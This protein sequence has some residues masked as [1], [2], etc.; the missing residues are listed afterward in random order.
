M[1]FLTKEISAGPPPKECLREIIEDVYE[2]SKNMLNG[3]GAAF[4]GI[5]LLQLALCGGMPPDDGEA[6]TSE[7]EVTRYN[8]NGSVESVS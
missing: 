5:G 1:F 8:V 7:L 2:E 3:M 6:E 4:L